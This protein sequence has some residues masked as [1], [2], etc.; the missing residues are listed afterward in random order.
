M[1]DGMDEIQ[2]GHIVF[3][4]R[5]LDLPVARQAIADERFATG[6]VEATTLRFTTHPLP[7]FA[8]RL[9]ARQQRAQQ[10]ARLVRILRGGLLRWLLIGG[11]AVGDVI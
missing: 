11:R 10:S 6:F 5:L 2:N 4:L 7:E 8:W 9:Q 1:T 3:E